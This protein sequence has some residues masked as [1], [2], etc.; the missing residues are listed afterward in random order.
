MPL[1]RWTLSLPTTKAHRCSKQR[2]SQCVR[3][4]LRMGSSAD[5]SRGA[6]GGKIVWASSP[7]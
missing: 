4:R 1:N 3:D 6:D 2:L 7:L 5:P